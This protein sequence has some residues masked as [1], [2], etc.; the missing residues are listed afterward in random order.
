M[1]I[2]LSKPGVFSA[3][4][5]NAEEL[6]NSLLNGDQSGIKRYETFSGSTFFAARIDEN[7]LS[8]ST[9]RFDMKI[10]RIEEAALRQIENIIEKAK[11]KGGYFLDFKK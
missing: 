5:K 10:I 7:A 11:E 6:W 1:K 9:G 4:G 2:Y 8:P 3:A